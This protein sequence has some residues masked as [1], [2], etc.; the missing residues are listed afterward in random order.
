MKYLSNNFWQKIIARWS[1][2]E[3]LPSSQLKIL[4]IYSFLYLSIKRETPSEELKYLPTP[5]RAGCNTRSISSRVTGLNSEFFFKT[6]C[7]TKAEEPCLSYYLPIAGKRKVGFTPFERWNVKCHQPRPCPFSMSITDSSGTQFDAQRESSS[8]MYFSPL[9]SLTGENVS[10]GS[11]RR[12]PAQKTWA[13]T[14]RPPNS[15][16]PAMESRLACHFV[17]PG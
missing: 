9:L 13:S 2:S 11:R 3:H 7:I 16:S 10:V 14:I 5:V 17:W 6:S 4:I 1:K 8:A 15:W 12:G